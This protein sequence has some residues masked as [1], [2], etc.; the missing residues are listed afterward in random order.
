MGEAYLVAWTVLYF[1]FHTHRS[2]QHPKASRYFQ[3][4][5][6]LH[7]PVHDYCPSKPRPFAHIKTDASAHARIFTARRC[8]FGNRCFKMLNLKVTQTISNDFFYFFLNPDIDHL[9]TKFDIIHH[10]PQ[11]VNIKLLTI[12]K[13][14][15]GVSYSP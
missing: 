12:W 4:A 2:L 3:T 15:K 9:Q 8:T 7:L 6:E 1:R 10:L 11:K 13:I 5:A 14:E